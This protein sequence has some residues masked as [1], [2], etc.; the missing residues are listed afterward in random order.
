[1]PISMGSES[2]ETL[3]K[4]ENLSSDSPDPMYKLGMAVCARKPHF[5]DAERVD[6]GSSLA[7]DLSQNGELRVE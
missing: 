1:M 3:C 6:P 7:S 5:G 2:G 4:Q